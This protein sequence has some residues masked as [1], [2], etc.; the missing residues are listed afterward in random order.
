MGRLLR[1]QLRLP[2]ESHAGTR[3]RS[4][5]RLRSGSAYLGELSIAESGAHLSCARRTLKFF[6]MKTR[7]HAHDETN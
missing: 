4:L 7:C 1:G 5:L 6:I 2:A 3:V